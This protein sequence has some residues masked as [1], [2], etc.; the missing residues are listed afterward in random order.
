MLVV[1]QS[2]I[3]MAQ[4]KT[5]VTQYGERV[6]IHPNANDGLTATDG[7]IQ[8]GGALTKPSTLTTTS[9][10]TLAIK[11]LQTGLSTDNILVTDADGILKL[12]KKND[13]SNGWLLDGN[14]N[15]ALKSVGTNDNFD[16]PIETNGAERI[17][18]TSDGQLL[19]NTTA[20]LAGGATAKVQINNGT[21]A[22]ALQIKD[23][24]QGDG[25]VLTSDANGLSTWQTS[26][27]AIVDGV[28]PIGRI[29]FASSGN[30]LLSG[31]IDLPVGD[32][33]IN[34]G[35]LI[36]PKTGVSKPVI[37]SNYAARLTFS[38]SNTDIVTTGFTYIGSNAS[39]NTISTGS[40]TPSYV[41]FAAGS[42]RVR[43]TS[44]GVLRLYL[45]NMGSVGAFGGTEIG[46]IANN[47][48]N[49]IYAIA[50]K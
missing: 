3:M 24:T 6:T 18:V 16:L 38:S 8:L 48:E 31:S 41:M 37:N 20:P 46:S 45:W 9:D 50:V 7:F 21:T 42:F 35:F 43:N 12:I 34:T 4:T 14:T 32:W 49:Y 11:G 15:G 30:N 40:A 44:G 5:V 39:L 19:V 36:N 29:D 33:L 2:G 1:I 47:G 23:G 28:R 22:G 25:K 27:V 26:R 13:L 10:Y 17:R